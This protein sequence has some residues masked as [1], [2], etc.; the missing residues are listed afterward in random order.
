MLRR[1]VMWDNKIYPTIYYTTNTG[2]K[3]D[4]SIFNLGDYFISNTQESNGEYKVIC[5]DTLTALPVAFLSNKKDIITIRFEN[6][7]NIISIGA[8]SFVGTELITIDLTGLYNVTTIGGLSFQNNFNAKTLILPNKYFTEKI[9]FGNNDPSRYIQTHILELTL[10][11]NEVHE[12]LEQNWP[13]NV[14]QPDLKIYVPHELVEAY[15]ERFPEL[16][17][18][19]HCILKEECSEHFEWPE[20][21]YPAVMYTTTD[22][23]PLSLGISGETSQEKIGRCFVHRFSS[24]IITI[25]NQ[26]LN[27]NLQLERIKFNKVKHS[28]VTS[29][30]QYFAFGWQNCKEIDLSPFSHCAQI[31]SYFLHGNI[32]LEKL[33]L[34][35]LSNCTS[36]STYFMGYT[37]CE[38]DIDFSPLS[39]IPY[40][41][42]SAK[43]VFTL[44][45]LPNV[46][47]RNVWGKDLPNDGYIYANG[48]IFQG[49]YFLINLHVDYKFIRSIGACIRN[50][51]SKNNPRWLS[52]EDYINETGYSGEIHDPYI[53]IYGI[54]DEINYAIPLSGAFIDNNI[55][56]GTR[57]YVEHSEYLKWLDRD[58]NYGKW[59]YDMDNPNM[60]VNWEGSAGDGVPSIIIDKPLNEIF[61]E[62]KDYAITF[63]INNE[64]I[65]EYVYHYT[66]QNGFDEYFIEDE[67]TIAISFFANNGNN[68]FFMSNFNYRYDIT[69]CYAHYA[70][71]TTQKK[72]IGNVDAMTSLPFNYDIDLALLNIENPV[73]IIIEQPVHKIYT[74]LFFEKSSNDRHDYELRVGEIILWL[75]L[76]ENQL[77]TRSLANNTNYSGI[78]IWQ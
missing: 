23:Q 38:T 65:C 50:S 75:D 34:S 71:V 9:T 51:F 1:R 30:P 29:T 48:T 47:L 40:N 5:K 27:R 45:L 3:L 52:K 74:D 22:N 7:E 15:K 44:N 32:C 53:Y 77:T 18:R 16:A 64:E 62:K 19:I 26:F 67:Q 35:P 20:V 31:N 57:F 41:Q 70:E 42:L 54:V 56:P 55:L 10:L 37:Y 36:L 58:I 25:P 63:I 73:K 8:M 49:S 60:L 24:E 6:C 43:N 2:V 33:D 4:D 28:A 11:G 14:I 21:D 39:K 12:Y 76:E 17:D 68:T 78:E 59:V 72:I 46:D 61:K 66:N 13:I 69:S